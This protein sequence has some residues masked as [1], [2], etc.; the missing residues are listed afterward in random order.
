MPS[1]RTSSCA[2]GQNVTDLEGRRYTLAR[3][4]GQ[5]GQ[6][7]VFEVR[8]GGGRLAVKLLR[9]ANETERE[10][11]H[12]RIQ[13][14]K[15]LD[16]QGLPIAAPVA[17]LRPPHAGY[18]MQLASGMSSLRVM[19]N[20]PLDGRSI[21]QWYVATGGLRARL[22]LLGTIV[23]TF[24]QLHG[25]GLI[26]GDPSPGNILYTFNKDEIRAF[27]I[28]ADNLH[29]ESD[30]AARGVFTPG[31]GAPE[32]IRGDSGPNTLTDTYALAVIAFEMLT[33]AHPFVGDMVHDGEPELEEAAFRGDLPWIEHSTDLHNRCTRGIDRKLVLSPVLMEVF[34]LAFEDGILDKLA[35]PGIGQWAGLFSQAADMTIVCQRCGASYYGLKSATCPWCSY[36]SPNMCLASIHLWDPQIQPVSGGSSGDFV[37]TPKKLRRTLANILLAGKERV[38]ILARHVSCDAPADQNEHP[39]VEVTYTKVDE[40]RVRNLTKQPLVLAKHSGASRALDTLTPAGEKLLPISP[41]DPHWFLHF[42][43]LDTPHRAVVFKPNTVRT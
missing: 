9:S 27:L 37:T 16:L 23:E 39:L 26:Y 21:S 6:G 15:R 25:R 40:I 11:L 35:R 33:L 1:H 32:L 36:A 34:K 29:I 12:R 10:R 20:P 24:G 7:A 5:G 41:N 19:M 2:P 8:E 4:V 17:V 3:L 31:Y 30:A 38:H 22:R 18:F 43:P 13:A 14:V 42:G 28:D